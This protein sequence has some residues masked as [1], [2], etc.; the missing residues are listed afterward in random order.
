[1]PSSRSRRLRSGRYSRTGYGVSGACFEKQD[2]QMPWL[3][4]S[5]RRLLRSDSSHSRGWNHASPS[6]D[7]R[8]HHAHATNTI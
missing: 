1:M 7:T 3:K 4:P 6:L 2:G 5:S 8:S